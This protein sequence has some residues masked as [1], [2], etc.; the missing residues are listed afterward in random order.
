MSLKWIVL[1]GAALAVSGCIGARP[2]PVAPKASLAPG[3]DT[4]TPVGKRRQYYDQREARYYYFS[5]T[6]GRYYWENGDPR[7]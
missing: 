6:T 5:P 7:F 4:A 3:A 1:A 2:A